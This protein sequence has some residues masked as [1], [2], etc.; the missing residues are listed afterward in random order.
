MPI[1]IYPAGVDV[2]PDQQS[3][4]LHQSVIALAATNRMMEILRNPTRLGGA[5]NRYADRLDVKVHAPTDAIDGVR[6]CCRSNP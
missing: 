4:A 2:G 1:N 5:E 6:D 3:E